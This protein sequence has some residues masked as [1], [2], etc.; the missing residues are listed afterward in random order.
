M[1]KTKKNAFIILRVSQALKDKITAKAQENEQ[2]ISVV[3]RDILD[4]NL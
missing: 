4:N 1:Q 3:A 2:T